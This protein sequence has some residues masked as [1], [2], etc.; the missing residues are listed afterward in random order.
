VKFPQQYEEKRGVVMAEAVDHGREAQ[1]YPHPQNFAITRPKF[2]LHREGVEQQTRITDENF[3]VTG[4][5][6]QK[7]L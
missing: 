2:R 5:G 3:S 6:D 7:T 1:D 4:P